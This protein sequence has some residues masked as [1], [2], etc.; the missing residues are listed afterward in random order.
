[1]WQTYCY[2]TIR[3]IWHLLPCHGN[4]WFL[5]LRYKCYRINIVLSVAYTLMRRKEP[6]GEW[7]KEKEK[8]QRQTRER[9]P[10]SRRKISGESRGAARGGN[11]SAAHFLN[12]YTS[13]L[14]ALV[15]V[16]EFKSTLICIK[17]WLLTCWTFKKTSYLKRRE[18]KEQRNR[19]RP[20]FESTVHEGERQLPMFSLIS[21]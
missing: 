14:S 8:E 21:L 15:L 2:K 1:M 11:G 17:E 10:T 9:S 19:S 18:A 16:W 3:I 12:S 13:Q 6:K 20:W 4:L 5:T 7:E